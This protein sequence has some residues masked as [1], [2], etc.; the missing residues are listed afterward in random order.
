MEPSTTHIG[1]VFLSGSLE[2]DY[3]WEHISPQHIIVFLYS[4]EMTL[5]YGKSTLTFVAGDT[6][7]VPKNQLLRV[8]KKPIDD[9]PFKAVSMLLSDEELRRFY[10]SRSILENRDDNIIKQRPIKAHPLLESFFQ[11]LFSYFDM[12]DELPESLVPIKVQE[13]LT[14]IDEVDKRASSILGTFSEIGKIDLEKYMEEHFMYNL[15][16]ERFAFLT[17]R[18]LTTFKS[19]FKKIFKKTPGKWLTEKR[20]NLAHF[21]LT[22]EKQKATEVYLIAGFENL[23]HFS[24]AFKKA[25]GVSPRNINQ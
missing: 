14:I 6:V 8:I 13:A 21:K 17:G 25:F 18:S 19:D 23:S 15:P 24:F 10:Q 7:L 9:Q 5:T 12:Q 1:R 2:E 4:G 20:L 16:L 3:T 22:N 11:S